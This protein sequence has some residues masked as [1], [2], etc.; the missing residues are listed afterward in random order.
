MT[1]IEIRNGSLSA[2]VLPMGATIVALRLMMD[3]GP[4]HL[5]LGF[6]DSGAYPDRSPHF[7]AIA[8]RYA[9]RIRDGRFT[10]DGRTCQLSCNQAGRHHLH[11]G[12]RGFAKRL[13]TVRE[14]SPD[15]ISLHYRSLDGEEGYP[16]TLDA[17]CTYRLIEDATLEVVLTAE[18][19]R[20]TIVNLVH[21][22][23]F[24]LDGSGTISP[25]RLKIDAAHYVPVDADYIPTGGIAPVADTVFDFR[26]MRS[27]AAPG[28][29][30]F[31]YDHCFL[32][33][34]SK[35]DADGLARAARL[36]A[37]AG[38]LAME[39]RT[40]EP[41]LHFYAGHKIATTDPGHHGVPYPAFSGLCLEPQL[42]PDSPNRPEFG[43]P[44]LR[45]GE[46]YCQ[47]SRFRFIR[48]P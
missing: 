18:T 4:R 6:P 45:P 22:S 43:D 28:A 37:A 32:L 46:R 41:A 7:G 30:P 47:I 38:D 20:P 26:E 48:L 3:E 40:T 9:N 34:G 8:G 17:F 31:P 39:V 1:P 23:Y 16:G 14:V 15:S 12:V 11:G 33:D 5:T 19:D 21:H 35:V 29:A 44:V 2:S 27:I 42:P 24:N 13:W 10:L 25:S 36:E